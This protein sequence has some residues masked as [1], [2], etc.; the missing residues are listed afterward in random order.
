MSKMYSLNRKSLKTYSK[1]LHLLN[2][3][4]QSLTVNKSL[5]VNRKGQGFRIRNLRTVGKTVSEIYR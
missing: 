4:I 5:T 1:E 3:E 2:T